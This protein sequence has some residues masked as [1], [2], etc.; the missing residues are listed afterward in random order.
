MPAHAT[1]NSSDNI[2]IPNTF[3]SGAIISSSQM[4]ENF[5][6]LINEINKLTNFLFQHEVFDPQD[7]YAK[8]FSSLTPVEGTRTAHYDQTVIVKAPCIMEKA[9]H[10]YLIELV[11]NYFGCNF[12]LDTIRV[13][14]SYPSVN[15]DEDL[16][17][18]T[19]LSS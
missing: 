4:N 3:N 14:W 15:P 2:T 8:T 7:P 16:S 13:W 9:N 1:D 19:N 18:P 5:I 11:G 12:C 6:F 17:N 10:P